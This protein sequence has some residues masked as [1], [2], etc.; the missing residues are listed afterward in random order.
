MEGW[1]PDY[2]QQYKDNTTTKYRNEVYSGVFPFIKMKLCIFDGR[3][4]TDNSVTGVYRLVLCTRQKN[5]VE[6]TGFI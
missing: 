1:R 2:V 6:F 5:T 4:L 3:Y